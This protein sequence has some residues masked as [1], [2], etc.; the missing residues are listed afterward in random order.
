MNLNILRTCIFATLLMFTVSSCKTES[1]A[2]KRKAEK[3]AWDEYITNNNLDLRGTDAETREADSIY[4]F[5]QTVPWPENLYFKTPSGAYLRI[6]EDDPDAM[7]PKT[8]NT[9]ILRFTAYDLS[10]NIYSMNTF[11]REGQVIVYTPGNGSPS[12]GINE[13]LA[14]LHHGSR[15]YVIVDSKIGTSEQYSSVITLRYDITSISVTR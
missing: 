5:S 2:K 7:A 9:V 12:V 14:Y 8:G 4:C 1:Y 6:Y 10:N 13:A 15:A 3:A 11:D